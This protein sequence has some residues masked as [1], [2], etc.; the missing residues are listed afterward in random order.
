[1]TIDKGKSKYNSQW[2]YEFWKCSYKIYHNAELHIDKAPKNRLHS[3]TV[4]F[5]MPDKEY[6]RD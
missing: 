4:S 3:G 2:C 1:M 6:F 5:K